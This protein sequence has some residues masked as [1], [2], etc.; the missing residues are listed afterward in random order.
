MHRF[1]VVC[2][3]VVAAMSAATLEQLSLEA[4][5]RESTAIVQGRVTG[6]RT[7]QA[8]PLLYTVK[9]IAV[10]RRWKGADETTVEVSLPGGSAGGQRQVFGGAP[11]LEPGRDYIL[12]LWTGP[13]GRT[14]ITGFSQ[15]VCELEA[16]SDG[17]ERVVR[18][19]SSDVVLA[20]GGAQAAGDGSLDLAF[21]E[22]SSRVEAALAGAGKQ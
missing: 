21:G 22:F 12:F 9:T 7:V 1:P 19:P 5:A 17:A 16:A 8:G 10:D 4:L 18:R 14:Q 3:L 13:S 15:G 11:L 2:V 6:E 20:P